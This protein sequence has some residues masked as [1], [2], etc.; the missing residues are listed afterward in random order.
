MKRSRWRLFAELLILLVDARALEPAEVH[1]QLLWAHGFRAGDVDGSVFQ[2]DSHQLVH[3][4]DA[5]VLAHQE[6]LVPAVGVQRQQATEVLGQT[7]SGEVLAQLGH[8]HHLN[9]RS[10]EER[11]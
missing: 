9:L 8:P 11:N 3:W 10:V 6:L 2:R 5:A 1:Q 7:V 4:V